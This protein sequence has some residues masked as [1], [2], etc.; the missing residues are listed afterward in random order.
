MWGGT[1]S[2][3]TV[4]LRCLVVLFTTSVFLFL[5]FHIKLIILSIKPFYFIKEAH[6]KC[7][8]ENHTKQK[9]WKNLTKLRKKK[10]EVKKI[11]K[12]NKKKNKSSNLLLPIPVIRIHVCT[13][14]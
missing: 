3:F 14:R 5:A 9:K 10:Q 4:C 2:Y 11:I 7:Y 8:E 1:S 13:C 6:E 12:A